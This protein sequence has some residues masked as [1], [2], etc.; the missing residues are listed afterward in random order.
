MSFDVVTYRAPS[1]W[2]PYLINGDASGM[3]DAEQAQCDAWIERIGLGAPVTCEDLGFM[4]APVLHGDLVPY[5]G[6]YT[7][8]SFLRGRDNG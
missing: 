6:D 4:R 1:A 7:E 5:A 2:A 8:Y 3:D